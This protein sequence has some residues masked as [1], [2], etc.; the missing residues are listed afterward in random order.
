MIA[1]GLDLLVERGIWVSIIRA[2]R[3]AKAIGDLQTNELSKKAK[4]NDQ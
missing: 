1:Y 4:E 2:L 3:T